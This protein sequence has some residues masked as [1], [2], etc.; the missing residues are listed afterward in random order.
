ME[1]DRRFPLVVR[2]PE[3]CAATSARSA[4]CP[5]RCQLAQPATTP[6][7]ARTAGACAPVFPPGMCRLP[8]W[9]ASR[10]VK[11]RAIRRED[12][13]RRAVVQ[14]NVRGRDL[15]GFVAEAQQRIEQRIGR[16]PEGYWL[17]W[18]GQY[19]NWSPPASGS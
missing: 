2:M 4:I 13:K 15:G 18:G 14:C 11:G 5:C 7:P 3:T 16:L 1:G 9:R 10:P 12:G 17:G 6:W 8:A 19:E